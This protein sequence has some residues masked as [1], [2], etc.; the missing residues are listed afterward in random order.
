MILLLEFTH[1]LT[2]RGI[3]DP[4]NIW[5]WHFIGA[6]IRQDKDPDTYERIYERLSNLDYP[7]S[8]SR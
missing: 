7:I 5:G 3:R 4:K 8:T 6:R 1:W 2:P